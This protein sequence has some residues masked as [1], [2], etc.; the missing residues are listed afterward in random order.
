VFTGARLRQAVHPAVMQR[1]GT[2][3]ILTFDKG[4]EGIVG[5]ERSGA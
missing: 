5:I 1:R 4:F 3:R 2:T